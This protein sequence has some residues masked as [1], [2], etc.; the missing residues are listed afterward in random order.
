[1]LKWFLEKAT[2]IFF[3][4]LLGALL[5]AFDDWLGT[6]KAKEAGAAEERARQLEIQAIRR[7]GADESRVQTSTMT[8]AEL[9][10][11]LEGDDTDK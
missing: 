6:V 9:D 5:K 4:K 10:A 8:D 7:K 11:E 1:M 3:G 2:S